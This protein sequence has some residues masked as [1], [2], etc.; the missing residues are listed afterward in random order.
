M[1]VAVGILGIGVGIVVVWV[2][3]PCTPSSASSAAAAIP[4]VAGSAGSVATT[5]GA[6]AQEVGLGF[7]LG[8][9][10]VASWVRWSAVPRDANRLVGHPHAGLPKNWEGLLDHVGLRARLLVS[11]CRGVH[12]RGVGRSVG[13][14][15]SATP[16]VFWT[17]SGSSLVGI[18]SF[19]PGVE[20]RKAVIEGLSWFIDYGQAVCG[21]YSGRC[22]S[23]GGVCLLVGS[24]VVLPPL[25]R[26]MWWW[27]VRR[28]ILVNVYN[29]V[30]VL[31]EETF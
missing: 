9:G 30:V 20:A 7:G 14:G 15:V 16:W 11:D 8:L 17:A 26:F 2:V 21:R 25:D 18:F 13:V 10:V 27:G 22:D 28:N 23:C 6:C 4:A 31:M 5:S 19:V 24:R 12:W 29:R 1:G 3:V